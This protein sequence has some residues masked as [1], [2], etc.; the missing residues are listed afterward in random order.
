MN[1]RTVGFIVASLALGGVSAPGLAQTDIAPKACSPHEQA[2]VGSG[3]AQTPRDQAQ[4]EQNEKPRGDS[5]SDKLAASGGVICPPD[6]V[7]S[8]IKAPAPGGGRTPVIPPPG[9]P[10]GNP[11]VQPK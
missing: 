10:G 6:N 2:T 8:A 1:I 11:N 4:N 9:S 7:D 5:L 3:G